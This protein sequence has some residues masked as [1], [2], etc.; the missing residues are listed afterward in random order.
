ML[1]LTE[2]KD[3]GG[4]GDGSDGVPK[5]GRSPSSRLA[6]SSCTTTQVSA[7][8]VAPRFR[9]RWGRDANAGVRCCVSP[10]RA[11]AAAAGTATAV[12]GTPDSPGQGQR[13][14][15]ALQRLLEYPVKVR[16]PP[17][18]P[19]QTGEQ[20]LGKANSPQRHG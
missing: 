16:G 12:A 17:R 6:S 3:D 19:V 7:A 11:R 13:G 14:G 2:F 18:E 9:K 5:P 4:T 8:S 20:Q 10:Q 1:I 15:K